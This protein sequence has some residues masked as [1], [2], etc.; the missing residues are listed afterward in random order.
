MLLNWK[1]KCTILLLLLFPTFVPE[2][3]SQDAYNGQLQVTRRSFS[4]SGGHL[5]VQ[6]DISYE[7]LRM[8]SDESVT[9][10]PI[11]SNR[12]QFLPLPSILINGSEKQRV[13]DRARTLGKSEGNKSKGKE[14]KNS[15]PAVVLKNDSK[16]PRRFTYKVSVPFK[17]W[18]T[19]SDLFMRTEECGCNGKQA[20]SFEDKIASGILLPEVEVP[21]LEKNVDVRCLSWV[22]FLPVNPENSSYQQPSQGDGTVT[23][24][25]L[26][27]LANSFTPGS[28]EFNDL[29]DL[30]ARLFPDNPEA[31]INAAAVALSKRDTRKA[32]RL[33]S[34]FSTRSEAF[35][36]M[37]VLCMLEGNREKAEV[38]L[39][40]A[41]SAG[42]AKAGEVLEELRSR[43]NLY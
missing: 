10:T 11:L 21:G 43:R 16:S 13:Y 37:G 29:I 28:A 1:N 35:N 32:R 17:D 19:E 36:N 4:L 24:G 22:N 25:G 30:T 23:L 40:M 39:E 3:H 42:V 27:A 26:I 14:P 38:Y 20:Q 6:M 34:R 7:G 2:L 12:G 9:L 5:L 15:V 33:L 8:P 41:S 31:N 18:M